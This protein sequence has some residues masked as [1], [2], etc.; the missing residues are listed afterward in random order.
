VGRKGFMNARILTLLKIRNASADIE[1]INVSDGELIPPRVRTQLIKAFGPRYMPFFEFYELLHSIGKDSR[2]LPE[3]GVVERFRDITRLMYP[4][5]TSDT[6]RADFHSLTTKIRTLLNQVDRGN[7]SPMMMRK[8]GEFMSNL[9]QRVAADRGA[10]LKP[11]PRGQWVAFKPMTEKEIQLERLKTEDPELYDTVVKSK[12]IMKTLDNEIQKAISGSNLIPSRKS[13]LGKPVHIGSDPITGEE[14][15]FDDDGDVLPVEEY[16]TKRKSK[17]QAQKAGERIF[18]PDLDDLRKFSDSDIESASGDV[19]FVALTDDPDKATALTRIYPTK[20]VGNTQVVI[21]GRFKGFA[22]PDLVNATGR[23][24]EGTAYDF[25][26][27]LGRP[28]PIEVKRPDGSLDLKRV[29]REPYVT[30]D[31]GKLLL[32]I[33]S[34]HAFTPLREKMA[35]VARL[36]HGVQYVPN[37]RRSSFTFGPEDFAFIRQAIGGM[38]LSSAAMKFIQ[39]YFTDLARHEKAASDASLNDY[40]AESIGGFRQGIQLLSKQKQSLAWLDSRQGSGVIALDTGIGKTATC[41]AH[42]LNTKKRAAEIEEL[43]GDA[44]SKRFLYVCP[45]ALQGNL[46][47]EAYIFVEDPASFLRDVDVISYREFTNRRNKNPDFG[48]EYHTIFFD[49]AQALK[50]PTSATSKAAMSLNHPRKVLLTASPME[51]S[52]SEVYALAAISNNINLNTKEGR[53]AAKAFLERFT[54]NVGGRVVGIKDDPTTARDMRVWVRRNLFYADKRSVDEM[55]LPSLSKTSTPVTMDPRVEELYR[56]TSEGIAGVLRGMVAKYRDRRIDGEARDPGI[57]QARIKFAKLFTALNDLSNNPEKFVPGVGNPKLD[58]VIR[59]LDGKAGTRSRVIVFTDSPDMAAKCVQ[60]IKERCPWLRVGVAYADRIEL[61]N[62]M[63]GEVKVWKEK[64]YI[65]ED[66]RTI[67]K[68]AWK[69]HIIK[70]QISNTGVE[71]LVL[72]STYATGQN[73]QAYDTVLHLDRDTWNSETM[74]QRTA[75]AWRQ[76]QINPVTEIV[77][78]T[79]YGNP[80]G[81]LDATL[82]E[83]RRYV[84]ELD[85]DLFDRIVVDSQAQALGAEFFEMKKTTSAFFKV[86][87]RIMDLALSPYVSQYRELDR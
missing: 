53:V 11:I 36:A 32:R 21:D 22:V 15:V 78:D 72:T 52:P 50:T 23:L 79:V 5:I 63:T 40:T 8:V 75:R 62:P 6:G 47:A 55:A 4:T 67:P 29:S 2:A 66:G 77:L 56:K 83:I 18:P 7:T 85:S 16:I 39:S 44:G 25:D 43:G 9:I 74:K 80:S 1:D 34:G 54:E 30:L 3:E 82:D 65:G 38:A 24:L 69:S 33:P 70:T 58:Q 51:R 31:Q 26:P 48:S 19:V 42:M 37:S 81:E 35:G 28:V 86:N 71:V 10:Y 49:E 68:K 46:A 57:E 59:I 13:L 45:T 12:E 41:I 76:G 64:S 73:L 27:K 20:M 61:S 87:R 17:L 60:K 14:L 84:Q